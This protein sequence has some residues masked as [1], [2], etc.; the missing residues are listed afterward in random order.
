MSILHFALH[1]PGCFFHLNQTYYKI[2]YVFVHFI[3][4]RVD[5]ECI[6]KKCI[7]CFQPLQ[8]TSGPAA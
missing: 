3:F 4:I 5:L 1:N 2:L 6:E 7:D 8:F